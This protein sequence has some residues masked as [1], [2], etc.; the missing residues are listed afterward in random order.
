[1]TEL[2][3]KELGQP[4]ATGSQKGQRRT[5]RSKLKGSVALPTPWFHT[6]SLQDCERINFCYFMSCVTAALG[7]W[8]NNSPK[9]YKRN[10]QNSRRKE[11]LTLCPTVFYIFPS[12]KNKTNKQTNKTSREFL[13]GQQVK[14]PALSLQWLQSLLWFRF[15]PWLWNSPMLWEWPAKQTNKQTNKQKTVRL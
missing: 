10:G 13:V 14:D 5:H 3:I 4:G 15:D 11:S 8:Y 2:Q 9:P 7:D 6:P 12:E 1:M